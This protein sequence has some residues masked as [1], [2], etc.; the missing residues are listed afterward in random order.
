MGCYQSH[1]A[2]HAFTL[3]AYAHTTCFAGWA[4]GVQTAVRAERGAGGEAADG[5]SGGEHPHPDHVFTSDDARCRLEDCP[6]KL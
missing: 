3:T 2:Y 4:G 6:I 5:D 1:D